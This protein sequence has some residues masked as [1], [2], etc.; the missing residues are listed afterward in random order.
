MAVPAMAVMFDELVHRELGQRSG[1]FRGNLA[2]R[3]VPL[4]R[5][6]RSNTSNGADRDLYYLTTTTTTEE[7]KHVVFIDRSH[8][9]CSPWLLSV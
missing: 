6:S 9:V 7:K 3:S 2:G 5:N 1:Q 8:L 4:L